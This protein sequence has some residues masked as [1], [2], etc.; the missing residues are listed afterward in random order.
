MIV[1]ITCKQIPG[2]S[3]PAATAESCRMAVEEGMKETAKRKMETEK[4]TCSNAKGDGN[5]KRQKKK[6]KH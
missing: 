6:R 4:V 3:V 5:K 1:K 2:F